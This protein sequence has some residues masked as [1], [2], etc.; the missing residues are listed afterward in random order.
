V[1]RTGKHAQRLDAE[2]ARDQAWSGADRHARDRNGSFEPKKQNSGHQNFIACDREQVFLMPLTPT[3]LKPCARD[4]DD[5][6]S[7][8]APGAFM[9]R[10]ARLV[11][12]DH[13]GSHGVML[14]VR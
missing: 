11:A 5:P 13:G 7:G 14:A 4:H 9:C 1:G 8:Q 10:Q 3:V 2:D 6:S 12:T